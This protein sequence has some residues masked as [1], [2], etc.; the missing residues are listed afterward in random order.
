MS[1]NNDLIDIFFNLIYRII[2]WTIHLTIT[3][4]GWIAILMI[5]ILIIVSLPL[6]MIQN[7]AEKEIDFSV[8]F[9]NITKEYNLK[10]KENADY[11]QISNN[12]IK[13]N[14]ELISRSIAYFTTDL[15]QDET[16]K[17]SKDE[18]EKYIKRNYFKEITKKNKVKV[19][20][21]YKWVKATRSDYDK[22]E[23]IRDPL[24]N[25]IVGYSYKK[26][27][28]K[29]TEETRTAKFY[30]LVNEST[31]LLSFTEEQL[32]QYKMYLNGIEHLTIEKRILVSERKINFP[33]PGDKMI[34]ELKEIYITSSFGWRIHPV[35]HE[36]Q[37]HNGIDIAKPKGTLVKAP[38]L[39][40]ITKIVKDDE[41]R[42]NYVIMSSLGVD[43]EFLHLDQIK[44]KLN[45]KV[46]PGKIIGTV[47]NTGRHTG[48]DSSGYHL[49][50]SIKEKGI[51]VDP[52]N[53]Y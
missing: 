7:E 3:S 48:S 32:E 37:F 46:V 53:Y 16:L 31:L 35:T 39:G 5:T 33:L 13:V 27:E 30:E 34:D 50:Y 52:L 43:F 8:E 6:M 15:G 49:H 42:G 38:K 10:N 21:G 40:E 44:V 41:T 18:Y 25:E 47:G 23:P 2:K 26:K 17:I 1:K 51:Y 20:D 45:E 11:L 19:K 14:K 9:Y 28:S 36:K 4:F 12:V 22:K 24:T 29:Y